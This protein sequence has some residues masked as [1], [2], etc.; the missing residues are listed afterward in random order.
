MSEYMFIASC[1]PY[2]YDTFS[3]TG[4]FINSNH[5]S[6]DSLLIIEVSTLKNDAI[7][8]IG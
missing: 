7:G 8:K 4:R 5:N 3:V 6:Q 1:V 2:H